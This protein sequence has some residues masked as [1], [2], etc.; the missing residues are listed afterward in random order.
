MIKLP[1]RQSL[2]SLQMG[3]EVIYLVMTVAVAAALILAAFVISEYHQV[4]ALNKIIAARSE[5]EL[6]PTTAPQPQPAS[7]PAPRPPPAP[8]LEDLPPI[9]TLSEARGYFF[10]FGSA[11]LTN[12]FRQKIINEVIPTL[13]RSGARYRVD[14]V[15][16]I[17]HTD[18]VPIAR[19][20]S[21]LDSDLIAYLHGDNTPD[22]PR[23]ADNVGLGMARAAA[24]ARVLIADGRLA[25]F[26]ILPLSAG[27]TT[28]V[29]GTLADGANTFENKERRRIEIRMRRRE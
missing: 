26:V 8:P 24:V 1:A 9:I 18:E 19:G 10:E 13:L 7:K 14:V 6:K 23:A 15:E 5:P 25:T 22:V 21:S 27:Q 29:D 11:E 16:V 17:G 3:Q 28:D 12:D 20:A 4:I 2:L